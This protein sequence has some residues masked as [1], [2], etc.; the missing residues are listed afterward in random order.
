MRGRERERERL[1]GPRADHHFPDRP[2]SLFEVPHSYFDAAVV[3]WGEQSIITG[4]NSGSDGFHSIFQ[5]KQSQPS[6]LESEKGNLQ[7]ET[8]VTMGA[9]SG[10]GKMNRWTCSACG[11][12]DFTSLE[13]QRSHFKSDFHRLNIKRRL[14]GKGPATE[15]EFE[16]LA[17]GQRQEED[18]VSSISGSDEEDSDSDNEI[19]RRIRPIDSSHNNRISLLLQNSG[20]ILDIWKCVLLRD[21]EK[22]VREKVNMRCGNNEE[23]ALCV[24]EQEFLLKLKIFISGKSEDQ[25]IWVILLSRGGHF[26][27]CVFDARKG[28]VLAHKTHHRYV[29][30]ARAGGKQSSKDATGRA[31]KSAGASLRRHNEA[32][33]QRDIRDVLALWKNY[34]QLASCI[35]VHAPSSNGHALFGGEDGPLHRNDARIR[36]VP[37]TTRR[38][39]FKEAKRVFNE[40]TALTFKQIDCTDVSDGLGSLTLDNGE[41]TEKLRSNGI[42]QQSFEDFS[43]STEGPTICSV[44]LSQ[45][46]SNRSINLGAAGVIQEN[47]STPLHNAARSGNVDLVLELLNDGADPCAKEER[48]RTPYT[49]ALNKETRNAFREFMGEHVEMWNWNL[50]NVPS[51]LT[52]EMKAAQA[53]KQA[54]KEAKRKAKAKELKKSR[55]KRE[56]EKTQEAQKGNS[57][58]LAAVASKLV[59]RGEMPMLKE[60]LKQKQKISA[61]T[62]ED[63]V[64]QEKALERE[65]RAS[66]AER[67]IFAMT[68]GSETRFE[69]NI[70]SSSSGNTRSCCSCCG[71]SLAGI[72]PFYRL[73]YQYCTTACVHVHRAVLEGE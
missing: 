67:R 35:F 26:A 57:E 49:V 34:L 62:L 37:L 22:L 47:S 63:V 70:S 15:E 50:A 59:C 73:S 61:S 31:P 52:D 18:D 8:L 41:D 72:I 66:A 32:A 1:M 19:S 64:K 30:R 13:D 71:V 25:N 65:K 2:T 17:Q 16:V 40:L 44:S 33:L 43:N 14:I 46:T 58:Q 54:E 39:T 60:S 20:D 21:G 3:L 42:I 7:E 5:L 56:Q 38:P 36:H 6:S 9:D 51:A 53:A 68:H 10:I 12:L 55:K 27:G 24:T 11:I 45:E 48:G 28:S 69:S 29:V 4:Q 23:R